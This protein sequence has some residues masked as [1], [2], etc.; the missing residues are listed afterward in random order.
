MQ[1][2]IQCVSLVK[3][4]HTPQQSLFSTS[5]A[6]FF[7]NFLLEILYDYVSCDRSDKQIKQW[8]SLP[9]IGGC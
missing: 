2:G 4:T 8:T 7:F 5:E 6:D 1:M 9:W 3:Q